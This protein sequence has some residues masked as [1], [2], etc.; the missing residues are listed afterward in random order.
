MMVDVKFVFLVQ[1]CLVRLLVGVGLLVEEILVQ[2]FLIEDGVHIEFQLL[3]VFE[4]GLVEVHSQIGIG[5]LIMGHK[6]WF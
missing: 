5:L 4:Q 2:R 1:F 3:I 6:V